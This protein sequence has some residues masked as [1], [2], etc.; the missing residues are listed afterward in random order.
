[1]GFVSVGILM[2][3]IVFI[4]YMKMVNQRFDQRQRPSQETQLLEKIAILESAG[5]DPGALKM[6]NEGLKQFPN[7]ERI[8]ERI[9]IIE[10]RL[11]E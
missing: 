10:H 8:R 1:M 7:N 2:L 3:I 4:F 6:A 9:K 11:S 5:D